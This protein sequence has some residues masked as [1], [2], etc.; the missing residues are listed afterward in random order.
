[1]CCLIVC[2]GQKRPS[3]QTLRDV[4]RKN[5]H[6]LGISWRK[7][8]AISWFKSND[9]HEIH[10]I[11]ASI[12]RTVVLHARWASVGGVDPEL[13]HPFPVTETSELD[14]QGSAPAVLFQN[15]TWFDWKLE[16]EH[17]VELG[18]ELPEGP[19]SDAR[20]AAWLS[21]IRNDHTWLAKQTSRWVYWKAK[22]APVMIG[23]FHPFEG[24]MF[25]NLNW[26]DRLQNVR[27]QT[28]SHP[29][30]ACVWFKTSRKHAK[31][32]R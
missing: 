3:I 25:S 24:C 28:R 12:T 11:A 8:G 19:M 5:P 7:Q 4:V 2:P 29:N 23:Q 13:R 32:T 10:S 15:G 16:V 31:T 9:V 6:G 20:A 30:Q 27:N 22:S 14:L 26:Q 17:A 18:N 21:F 1:M